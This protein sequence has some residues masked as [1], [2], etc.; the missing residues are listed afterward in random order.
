[1]QLKK[2]ITVVFL[3]FCCWT[4]TAQNTECE[5]TLIQAA[6][7]FNS[8]HFYEIPSLLKPCLD[9]NDFTKEQRV[10]AY[11]LL[12]Q[13]YLIIDDPIAAEDSYLKLLRA[14]PEYVATKEKDPIDVVYLSTK[15][16]STPIFTPHAG[17]GANVSFV[18]TIWDNSV[19]PT[20]YKTKQILKPGF[21]VGG[22]MDWNIN[23]HWSVCADVILSYKTFKTTKIFENVPS[24]PLSLNGKSIVI[25]KQYWMDVPLYLKYTVSKGQIRPFGYV[26]YAVNSLLGSKGS[27]EYDAQTGSSVVPSTGQDEKFTYRRMSL[28]SSLVLGGGVRYKIGTDYLYADVRYM[29]GLYNLVGRNIYGPTPGNPTNAAQVGKFANSPDSPFYFY[30]DSYFRLDNLSVSFGYVRPL[31]KPR[32]IKRARTKSVFRKIRR[33]EK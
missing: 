10:R 26:G 2:T 25:E 13:A 17:I 7:E 8:G 33:E 29:A 12:S 21:M 23:E 30:V 27:L 20:A 3:F 16:T 1:M 18:R 15:F 31:Y 4:V 22:G 32:K 6:D 5:Q 19:I 11:L 9:K 24:L 28:N 14:D